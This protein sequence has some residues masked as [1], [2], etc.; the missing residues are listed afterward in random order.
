M[1]RVNKHVGATKRAATQR[2]Q[3]PETMSVSGV[4]AK[5]AWVSHADNSLNSFSFMPRLYSRPHPGPGTFRRLRLCNL[6]SEIEQ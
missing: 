6:T 4:P 3:N 2:S 5:P 1:K